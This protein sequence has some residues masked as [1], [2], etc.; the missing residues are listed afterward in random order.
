MVIVALVVTLLLIFGAYRGIRN[1]LGPE[2]YHV[3]DEG[4]VCFFFQ[5]FI[6]SNSLASCRHLRFNS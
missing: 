5:I 6:N 4:F 3:T 2:S 1:L